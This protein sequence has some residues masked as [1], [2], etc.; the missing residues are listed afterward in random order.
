MYNIKHATK[1]SYAEYKTILLGS[2]RLGHWFEN[3]IASGPIFIVLFQLW[4]LF[5]CTR[6]RITKI[7]KRRDPGAFQQESNG[8]KQKFLNH[9]WKNLWGVPWGIIFVFP[10]Q[11]N[12]VPKLVLACAVFNYDF[13]VI[14]WELFWQYVYQKIP[15]EITFLMICIKCWIT[16]IYNRLFQL[17]KHILKQTF[18]AAL[19][20]ER[21]YCS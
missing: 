12:V 15:F 21:W 13:L 20:S 4:C 10:L 14:S 18:I 6:K 1:R 3:L 16:K 11:E 9:S 5:S 19:A 8:P 2:L 7:G 17:P